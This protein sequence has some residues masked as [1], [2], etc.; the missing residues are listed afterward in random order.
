MHAPACPPVRVQV[1]WVKAD[2]FAWDL[3][4]ALA[5]RYCLPPLLVSDL[6]SIERGS[7]IEDFVDGV[8]WGPGFRVSG[9]RPVQPL[10]PPACLPAEVLIDW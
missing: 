5:S 1:R 9:V 3:V 8:R 2:G 6:L 7:V 10:R 4:K